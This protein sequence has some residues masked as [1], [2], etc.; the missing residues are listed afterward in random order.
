MNETIPMVSMRTNSSKPII[1]DDEDDEDFL[2]VPT[3]IVPFSFHEMMILVLVS[4]PK[5]G[6]LFL[7]PDDC[8]FFVRRL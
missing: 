7:L 2:P 1:D 6:E 8:I 5:E 4:V 3:S